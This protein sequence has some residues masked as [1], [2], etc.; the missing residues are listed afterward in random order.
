[1]PKNMDYS[2]IVLTKNSAPDGGYILK[3]IFE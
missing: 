1:M 2:Y 3:S